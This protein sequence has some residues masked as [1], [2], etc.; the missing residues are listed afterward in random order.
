MNQTTINDDFL[1][2]DKITTASVQ[3]SDNFPID[4]PTKDYFDLFVKEI[5][6]QGLPTMITNGSR[7]LNTIGG[8]SYSPL[9][10]MQYNLNRQFEEGLIDKNELDILLKASEIIF[11]KNNLSLLP[12][13]LSFEDLNIAALDK[14]LLFAKA[15]K[16]P[17][18]TDI[19]VVEELGTG[20]QF[21]IDGQKYNYLYLYYYLRFAFCASVVDFEKIDTFVEIGSG[22][23]RSTEIIKRL[24]P[25]IT[26]HLFDIGPQLYVANRYL[27]AALPNQIAPFGA[28][29]EQTGKI[30]FHPHHEIEKFTPQ[31]KTISWATM[32]YC[33]MEPNTAKAYFDS[34][35]KFSDYIYL[36]EPMTS[37]GGG[38][39][40]LKE[41]ME[42]RHYEQFIQ[43]TH[44]LTA[45]QKVGRPLANIKLWGGVEE[46]VWSKK[47]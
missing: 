39:Y 6:E 10:Q 16:L 26:C 7:L 40:G 19:P 17:P 44:E 5:K 38:Q 42:R 13:E 47:A 28:S 35:T 8:I 22:S 41:P 43:P 3:H 4:G 27:S 45:E 12:Y 2:L 9:Q 32:V 23:G 21:E 36:C 14:A 29:E 34:L 20:Y 1:L 30:H 46:M 33:I 25:H 24:Y 37:A 11:E 18:V 15:Q 31:G